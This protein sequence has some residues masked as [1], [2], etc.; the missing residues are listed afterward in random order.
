[1]SSGEKSKAHDVF[2]I[3]VCK[4]FEIYAT[5]LAPN[6]FDRCV[7]QTIRSNTSGLKPVFRISTMA[8]MVVERVAYTIRKLCNR[9]GVA[10]RGAVYCA[11]YTATIHATNGVAA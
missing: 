1:M 9:L 6:V 11:G 7:A 8:S 2:Y 3:R 5:R 10:S 4:I